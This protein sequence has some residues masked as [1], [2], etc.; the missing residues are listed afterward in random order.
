M[1][2]GDKFMPKL[3]YA[4]ILLAATTLPGCSE[5]QVYSAIQ[6]NQAN[7]C[8]KVPLS[9][10]NACMKRAAESYNDYQNKREEAIQKKP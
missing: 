3:Q 8:Q 2:V 9:E 1:Y 6:S 5:R 7:E 4:L 10:Y